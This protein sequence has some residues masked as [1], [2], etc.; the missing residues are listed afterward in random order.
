[1]RLL[2][3]AHT[4]LSAKPRTRAIWGICSALCSV[5]HWQ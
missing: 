2:E 4:L 5:R 1:M 3:M